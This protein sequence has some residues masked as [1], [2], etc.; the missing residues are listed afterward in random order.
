ME[1]L[2]ELTS[3]SREGLMPPARSARPHRGKAMR[4]VGEARLR[5]V[6]PEQD[7]HDRT[8]GGEADDGRTGGLGR[9]SP[10]ARHH[11][12]V[13]VSDTTKT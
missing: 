9:A 6:P 10:I 13:A 8:E 11:G 3:G 7:R 1:E 2:P 12:L 5:L 4:L